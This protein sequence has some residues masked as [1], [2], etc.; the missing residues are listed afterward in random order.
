MLRVPGEV[1]ASK[2]AL[3]E[4]GIFGKEQNAALETDHVGALGNGAV[5][6]RVV[7]RVILP[8]KQRPERNPELSFETMHGAQN[9]QHIS[10]R[11]D[12]QRPAISRP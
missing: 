7:H 11:S 6:Q 8:Q 12:A 2:L 9:R 4:L 5:Q 1:F 10:N 3:D